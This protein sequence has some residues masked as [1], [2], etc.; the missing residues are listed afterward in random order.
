MLQSMN[1]AGKMNDNAHMES[2]F[3]SRRPRSCT[4]R[5]STTTSSFDAP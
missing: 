4:A 3:H 2:F 5:P 1:R